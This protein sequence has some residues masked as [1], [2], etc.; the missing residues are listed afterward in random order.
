MAAN[1]QFAIAVH[2]LAMLAN[3]CDER[4]KSDYIAKSVNTNPVVIRRLLSTLYENGLV[5]SQTGACGGSC[6]TRKASSI[7]LLEIYR[8]V[9]TGEVF[10]LPRNEP[11]QN[12]MVGKNIQ[13]VLEKVQAEIDIAIEEKLSR[14]TLQDVIEMVGCEK[15]EP[16]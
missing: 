12:C 14:Y 6:L 13:T 3:S 8:S 1:S 10:S 16:V 11:D 2:I 5:V 9:C 7:S 15:A 4:I